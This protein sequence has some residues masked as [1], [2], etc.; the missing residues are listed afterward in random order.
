VSG[1]EAAFVS[2]ATPNGATVLSRGN[3]R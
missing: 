1:K 2:T 3:R